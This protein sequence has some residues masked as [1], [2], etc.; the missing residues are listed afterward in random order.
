MAIRSCLRDCPEVL[1]PNPYP[2]RTPGG[3]A[4]RPEKRPVIYWRAVVGAGGVAWLLI[5]GLIGGA[6]VFSL[7]NAPHNALKVRLAALKA[8]FETA[9][10]AQPMVVTTVAETGVPVEKPI[11]PATQVQPT[12]QL[13]VKA[14]EPTRPAVPMQKAPA[15]P[16]EPSVLDDP[17]A[18]APRLPVTEQAPTEGMA[19]CETYGTQVSFVDGPADA[20]QQALKERKLLFMLHLSGNFEDSKF[21]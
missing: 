9:R 7:G 19:A 21:T 2:I 17:V 10:S 15:S 8:F 4:T 16:P 14:Q 3:N 12:T 5:A 11:M 13:S 6:Y 18:Q 1:S 20:A